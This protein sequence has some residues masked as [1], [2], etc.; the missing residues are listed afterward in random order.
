MTEIAREFL[1]CWI[2]ENIASLTHDADGTEGK[3]I[4]QNVRG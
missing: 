4:G 3:G 1:V 2:G